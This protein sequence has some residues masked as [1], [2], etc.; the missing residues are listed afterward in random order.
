MAGSSRRLAPSLHIG[1]CAT[2]DRMRYEVKRGERVLGYLTFWANPSRTL[3]EGDFDLEDIEDPDERE[4]LQRLIDDA[5][6]ISPG[7]E[8]WNR[9]DEAPGRLSDIKRGDP[10]WFEAL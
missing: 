8:F 5:H 3:A 9:Q 2:I 4:A 7:G 10:R 6:V 1:V